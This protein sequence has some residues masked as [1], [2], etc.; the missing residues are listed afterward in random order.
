M[1][2]NFIFDGWWLMMVETENDVFWD[3]IAGRYSRIMEKGASGDYRQLFN[4]LKR[5]VSGEVYV[6][7]VGTGPGLISFELCGMVGVITAVDFSKEMIRIAE[8]K[9]IKDKIDNIRFQQGNAEQLCFGDDIF[10]AV[11]SSNVLHLLSSPERAV[12][13]MKRVLKPGGKL[14]VPTYCHGQSL[15]SR[16][17]SAIMSLSGFKALTKWSVSGFSDFITDNGFNIIETRLIKG[18]IPMS[19]I[20]AKKGT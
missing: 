13:E 9:R 10:D 17:V 2:V 1:S 8:E 12:S 14:I 3:R 5:D 7:E 18:A 19:Y 20:Y 16:I 6:L 11:I 15:L 4:E